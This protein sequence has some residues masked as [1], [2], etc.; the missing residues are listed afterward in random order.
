MTDS[1]QYLFLAGLGKPLQIDGRTVVQM[2]RWEL[3]SGVE[4]EIVFLGDKPFCDNAAAIAID[5]PGMI[6]L[7]DG[8][9]AKAV[10]IW[11]EPGLPR[12]VIHRVENAGRPLKIYNKYRTRHAP[13]FITEDSFTGNAGM[14]VTEVSASCRRYECSN[15]P[16]PFSPDDLVFEVRVR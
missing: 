16:G 3:E 8:R 6:L 2:D 4:A 12:T 15:G 13:D 9:P 10:A 5:R 1:L 7:S 14:V 11:D